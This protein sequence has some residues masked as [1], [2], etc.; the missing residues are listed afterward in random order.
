[1]PYFH[2]VEQNTEA[3]E[4]LRKGKATASNFSKILT[5]AKLKLSASAKDYAIKL[6]CER[7]GISSPPPPPSFWMDAGTEREPYAIAEFSRTVNQPVVR[8][9]FVTPDA[10]SQ[11]GCSPDGLVGDDAI[12]EIKCPMIE[13][14][15]GYIDD[16]LPNDYRLQ[17]QGQLW[18]TEREACHFYVWNEEH[19]PL[20][21]IVERDEEVIEALEDAMPTFLEMVDLYAGKIRKRD[22]TP[23][24]RWALDT[25]EELI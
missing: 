17:V 1:M 18:I 3:W 13:T 19:E 16:G 23:E 4:N 5:P 6:A 14:L 11:Y 2:N 22:I 24:M 10:D 20:H 25:S 7:K 15:I 12:I 21:Y 8:V 9:G